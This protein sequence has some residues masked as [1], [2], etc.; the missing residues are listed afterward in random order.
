[1]KL[2]TVFTAAASLIPCLLIYSPAF[3]ICELMTLTAAGG[4]D[5]VISTSS[6]LQNVES[7][8][9]SVIHTGGKPAALQPVTKEGNA[10]WAFFNATSRTNMLQIFAS[11]AEPIRLS[12]IIARVRFE[13]ITAHPTLECTITA[14]YQKTQ[15]PQNPKDTSTNTGNQNNQENQEND[16]PQYALNSSES[17]ASGFATMAVNEGT[18]EESITTDE[19]P[20]EQAPD[21]QPTEDQQQEEEVVQPEQPEPLPDPQPQATTPRPGV[22]K[23]SVHVVHRSIL[24]RF[25]EATEARTPSACMAL[26][27]EPVTQGFSQTPLIGISDGETIITLSV[28]APEDDSVTPLFVLKGARLLSLQRE[29][30]GFWTVKA[31]PDKGASEAFLT[32]VSGPGSVVYPLT[33]VPRIIIKPAGTGPVSETDFAAFLAGAPGTTQDLNGDGKRDYMDDY[34]FTA[35]YLA[36]TSSLLSEPRRQEAFPL[37][38]QP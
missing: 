16:T 7:I 8:I 22:A 10:S 20:G 33:L 29:T 5:Y 6:P 4:N 31:L 9:L 32:V 11:S 34:I 17:S 27:N 1:M 38:A 37:P 13:R 12:G 25:R 24:S 35:N 15:D 3:G 28:H 2:R 21:E 23:L 14:N 19:A 18:Q 30:D 26:F 36:A